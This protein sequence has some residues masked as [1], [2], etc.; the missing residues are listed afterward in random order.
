MK[1]KICSDSTCDLSTGLIQK[2]DISVLPL[3]VMKDGEEHRDGVDITPDDIYAFTTETGKLCTT[4][5]ISVQDYIDF[6]TEQLADCDEL[7]HFHI[8]SDMSSCYQNACI[9]AS[10]LDKKV[11]PVDAR[12]LST[13]IGQLVLA[14]AE[15]AQAGAS[16]EEIAEAMNAKREKL[17]VSF[18]VDTLVYLHKGGRCSAVAALGAN[19]LSLKPCIEVKEG[20]MGVGKKYRGSMEKCLTQYVRDRLAG[21]DDVDTKRIFITH[22]GVTPDLIEKVRDEVLKHQKFEEVLITRAGSTIS[23]HCGPGTLGIL[24]LTK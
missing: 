19:L 8:S 9:A 18:V 11:Y 4:A 20:T 5:A 17:D 6:F 2:Y 3:Y 13:G 23:S 22:S 10:E 7:V 14:A 15:M 24:F 16:G 1:I 12:N 21:R